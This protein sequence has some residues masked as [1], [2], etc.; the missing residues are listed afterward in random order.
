[1]RPAVFLDRDGVLNRVLVCNGRP[2]PPQRVADLEIPDDVPEALDVLVRAGFMLIGVTNQPDVARGEQRREV[3]E[4]INAALLARL[5][6]A[7]LL[8]CYHDDHDGCECRKP[9]PGLLLQAANRYRIDL[10]A[11]FM[12]GDR[13]KDVEAGRRAGCTTV[14]LGS[15]W[16]EPSYGAPADHAAGSL[17]E[18]ARWIVHRG[19]SRKEEGA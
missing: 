4:A 7:A 14:L 3:V 13:W 5:P 15:G 10:P 17:R 2:H 1:M 8:V 19:V 16:G 9:R 6:L 12:V 18:A 11:S